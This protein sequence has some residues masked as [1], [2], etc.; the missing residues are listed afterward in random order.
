MILHIFNYLLTKNTLI[1]IEEAV[2]HRL[3]DIKVS[4]LVPKWHIL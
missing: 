1:L 4:Y 2:K 3:L